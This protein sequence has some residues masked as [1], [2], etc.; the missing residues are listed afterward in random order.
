MIPIKTTCIISGKGN[1][2]YVKS[3]FK[4]LKNELIYEDKLISKEELKLEIFEYIEIW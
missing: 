4:S 1:Y 3:F 2:W